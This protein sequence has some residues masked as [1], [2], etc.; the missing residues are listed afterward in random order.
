MRKLPFAFLPVLLT[1][2]PLFMVGMGGTMLDDPSWNLRVGVPMV[3]T[4]A[5]VGGLL[6]LMRIV[7]DQDRRIDEL[8]SEV[9]R[10]TGK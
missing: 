8:T 9:R 10:L 2:G 7:R 1:F 4:F 5:T 3:G 6:L